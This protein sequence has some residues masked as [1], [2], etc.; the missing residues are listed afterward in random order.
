MLESIW[1]IDIS[2]NVL[3]ATTNRQR[4]RKN[5]ASRPGF[6]RPDSGGKNEKRQGRFIPLPL[7][8]SFFPY[9]R[10]VS[11]LI[12]TIICKVTRTICSITSKT[13]RQITQASSCYGRA[14]RAAY[15]CGFPL[16][17][18]IHVDRY[19]R[20]SLGWRQTRQHH[21]FP[22]G[23]NV[24]RLTIS[25]LQEATRRICQPADYKLLPEK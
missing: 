1:L 9:E 20:H 10:P 17:T 19:E 5:P 11:C 14:P 22:I 18:R 4:N 16:T 2:G 25:H 6:F 23:K 3:K 24:K 7:S 12:A 21:L 15:A 8:S 13:S